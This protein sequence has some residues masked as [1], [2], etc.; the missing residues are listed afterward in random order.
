MTLKKISE[1]L[2]ELGENKSGYAQEVSN[3]KFE[4]PSN[5]VLGR[6]G[7]AKLTLAYFHGKKYNEEKEA[8]F[9]NADIFIF[10]TL[11]KAFGLVLLEAME[12]ALP[13]STQIRA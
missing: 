12:H 2:T 1:S 13:V 8:F 11:N 6:P 5:G 4:T 9:E 7:G 10:P 3:R